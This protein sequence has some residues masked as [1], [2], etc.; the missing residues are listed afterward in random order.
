MGDINQHN[1]LYL[2][3]AHASSENKEQLPSHFKDLITV[4]AEAH[5]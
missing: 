1:D 3:K 4:V 2:D 5:T